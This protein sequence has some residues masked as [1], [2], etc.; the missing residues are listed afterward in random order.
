MDAAAAA[1]PSAFAVPPADEQNLHVRNSI[2]QTALRLARAHGGWDKVHVHE[3]ARESGMSLDQL[4]RH[5][6]DKDAIA[7][8]YFD[9]ADQA[10]RS[11]H[12]QH[13]WDHLPV[14][15]RLHRAIM[16]WFDALTPHREIAAGMLRY[17]ARPEHL[18]L[19]ARG[20]AR[21]GRTVQWIRE[22]AMLPATGIRREIEEAVLTSIF[23][24][25]LS[26][27]AFDRSLGNERTHKVLHGLLRTAERGALWFGFGGR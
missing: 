26:V 27:W 13:G 5:F 22:A 1:L 16:S 3:V 9:S 19:Q 20:L 14:R 24:A 11:A 7:E 2:V 6:P 18:H 8:A 15:E 25:A 10:L 17:K 23:L 21:I 4:S 12:Q